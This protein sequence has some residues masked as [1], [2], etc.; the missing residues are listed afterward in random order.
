[1]NFYFLFFSRSECQI[2]KR[3]ENHLEL[4]FFDTNLIRLELDGNQIGRVSTWEKITE[5]NDFDVDCKILFS[6]DG[7]HKYLV[8]N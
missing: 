1:M 5:K 8:F 6:N 3:T 2:L 4:G 7:K